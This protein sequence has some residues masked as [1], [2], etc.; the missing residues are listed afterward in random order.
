VARLLVA[1]GAAVDAGWLE[2]PQVRADA[3]MLAALTRR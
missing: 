3:E 1:A 2:R